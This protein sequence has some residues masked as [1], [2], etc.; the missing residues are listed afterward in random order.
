MKQSPVIVAV[1]AVLLIVA[2]S[3][4]VVKSGPKRHP[5]KPEIGVRFL[6]LTNDAAGKTL[7]RFQLRNLGSMPTEVSL[8]GFIDLGM[9]G[10]GYFGFTNATLR[11][12]ATLETCIAPPATRDH[13]R[14]EF[15]CSIR[16]SLMYQS[17]NLAASHGLP[18][19]RVVPTVISVYSGWLDSASSNARPGLE[20]APIDEH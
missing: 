8:P 9:T 2:T 15:L 19:I 10:G 20:S 14:A 13:W 18:V 12:G 6:G 1:V 11:P 3:S 4:L 7:A 17:K 5:K 16:L